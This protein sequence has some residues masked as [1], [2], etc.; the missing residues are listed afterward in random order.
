MKNVIYLKINEYLKENYPGNF[1]IIVALF[2][3]VC[4]SKSKFM[5]TFG[6]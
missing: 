3:F 5:L 6:K 2:I 1:E 4:V